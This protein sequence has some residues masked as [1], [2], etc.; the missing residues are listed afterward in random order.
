MID[1][2]KEK[3]QTSK[4][5]VNESTS[6][7]NATNAQNNEDDNYEDAMTSDDGIN[8]DEVCIFFIDDEEE[9]N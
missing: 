2:I 9:T 4:H 8:E 7:T 1:L 3:Y 5:E 6:T